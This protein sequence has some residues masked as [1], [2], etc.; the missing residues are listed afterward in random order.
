MGNTDN[1]PYRF[2]HQDISNNHADSGVN[3]E[4]AKSG[5]VRT[6]VYTR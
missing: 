3:A 5:V 2:R 4:A 6:D 1:P